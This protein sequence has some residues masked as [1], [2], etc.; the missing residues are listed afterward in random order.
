MHFNKNVVEGK[1]IKIRNIVH[2][3]ILIISTESN[4]KE[5]L[6]LEILPILQHRYIEKPFYFNNIMFSPQSYVTTF[7]IE[8]LILE[9]TIS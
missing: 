9:R 8:G 6:V 5:S 7:G 1:A 3:K 4:W 2:Y